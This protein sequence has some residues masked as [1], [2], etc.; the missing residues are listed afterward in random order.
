VSRSLK[1]AGYWLVPFHTKLSGHLDY[2][3]LTSL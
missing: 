3:W 1:L 2:S